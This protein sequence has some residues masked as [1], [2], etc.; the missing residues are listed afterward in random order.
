MPVLEIQSALTSDTGGMTSMGLQS[1]NGTTLKD[2]WKKAA[3]TYL[4]TTVSGYPNML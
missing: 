2:E 1:I 3:Y 4:G